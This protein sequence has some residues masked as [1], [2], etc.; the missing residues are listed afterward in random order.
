LH[1]L[2][3]IRPVRLA[4]MPHTPL[5]R[6]SRPADLGFTD[7][8]FTDVS[9][10]DLDLAGLVHEDPFASRVRRTRLLYLFFAVP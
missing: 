3:F 5:T 7:H 2:L 4:A 9:F 8:G 6:D 1:D 10:A